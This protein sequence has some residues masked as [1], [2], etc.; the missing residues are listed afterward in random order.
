M[1]RIRELASVFTIDVAAYAVMRNHNHAVLRV[2]KA[3]ALALDDETVLRRWTS[4]PCWPP[5]PMWT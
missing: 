3:R 5:W 2:D 4:R 1:T